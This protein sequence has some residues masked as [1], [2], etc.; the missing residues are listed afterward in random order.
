MG[1]ASTA[2]KR[3]FRETGH[4]Q[5]DADE[6]PQLELVMRRVTLRRVANRLVR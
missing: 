3:I 6:T 2:H 5:L 4:V 1:G